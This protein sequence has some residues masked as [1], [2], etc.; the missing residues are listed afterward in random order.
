MANSTARRRRSSHRRCAG[1]RR[2]ATGKPPDRP[3][4]QAIRLSSVA[5]ANAMRSRTCHPIPVGAVTRHKCRTASRRAC[6]FLGLTTDDDH[7]EARPNVTADA[8]ALYFPRRQRR[9][10]A[11]L[12]AF[13]SNRAIAPPRC[14]TCTCRGDCRKRRSLVED[15]SRDRCSNCCNSAISSTSLDA[16]FRAAAKPD[17]FVPSA[18]ADQALPGVCHLYVVTDADRDL[19]LRLLTDSKTTRRSTN[20]LE[21]LLVHA[22]CRRRLPAVGS[23]GLRSRRGECDG[24]GRTR[25]FVPDLVAASEAYA[26]RFLDLVIAVRVVDDLGSHCAATV[27]R[28]YRGHRDAHSMT[29]RPDGSFRRALGG[30]RSQCLRRVSATAA[31]SWASARDPAFDPRAA[32]TVRWGRRSL[33]DRALRRA[34]QKGRLRFADRLNRCAAPLRWH[35]CRWARRMR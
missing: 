25:S 11:R 15:A 23:R 32:P 19:A 34:R 10:A 31:A 2:R 6:A 16:R 17:R 18:R 5:D 9:A 21:T 26:A 33:D 1:R 27:P 35:T 12:E 3:P 29:R 13:H 14:A 20:S 28:S 30:R 8:A 4:P 24:C 22:G 7:R